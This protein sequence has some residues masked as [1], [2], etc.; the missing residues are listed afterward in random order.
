MHQGDSIAVGFFQCGGDVARSSSPIC[1]RGRSWRFKDEASTCFPCDIDIEIKLLEQSL[2]VV[3]RYNQ[4]ECRE[5]MK[6]D[7]VMGTESYL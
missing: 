3:F 4:V 6:I 1:I 7:A 5:V 2:L